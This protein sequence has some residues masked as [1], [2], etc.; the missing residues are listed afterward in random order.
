V[1]GFGSVKPLLFSV[2]KYFKKQFDNLRECVMVKYEYK[3]KETSFQ[4]NRKETS[5]GVPSADTPIPAKRNHC[6]EPLC[7][8]VFGDKKQFDN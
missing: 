4:R 2:T 3:N 6:P 8:L 1:P 7:R 5:S